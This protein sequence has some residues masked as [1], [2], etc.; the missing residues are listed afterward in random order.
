MG[1]VN[2]HS[3]TKKKIKIYTQFASIFYIFSARTLIATFLRIASWRRTFVVGP[4]TNSKKN[5][6]SYLKISHIQ[7]E[8][9]FY[10]LAVLTSTEL[11]HH[12]KLGLDQKFGAR[13]FVIGPN[14][15]KKHLFFLYK[16]TC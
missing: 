14:T 6:N 1:P 13:T 11:L 5:A 2:H 16:G 7:G 12:K 9:C 3:S 10:C 4:H 15:I 8:F